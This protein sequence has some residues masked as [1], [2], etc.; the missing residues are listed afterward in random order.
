MASP[1]HHR[2]TVDDLL[3]KA[4][5]YGPSAPARLAVLAEAQIHAT[6]YLAELTAAIAAPVKIQLGAEQI[7]PES[8]QPSPGPIFV[9]DDGT[10]VP[11]APAPAK[12]RTRKAP[13]APKEA[14]K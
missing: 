13:S 12:R 4:K 14:E 5:G 8:F 11:E 2:T 6:L 1:E 7:V 9:H 3:A 10:P